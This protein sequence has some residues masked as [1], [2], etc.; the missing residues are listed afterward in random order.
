MTAWP[1]WL[2]ALAVTL[3][4]AGCADLP[5]DQH[6]WTARI[7]SSRVL[8]VG[9]SATPGT[10]SE[11]E[12]RE[13]RLVEQVAQKLGA[14]IAWR[15][16]NVHELLQELEELQLPLVVA[17]VPADSPFAARIGLSQPY[18][19]DG[20]HHRDYCLAVAPGENQLLLLVD[21]IIAAARKPENKP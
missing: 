19:K 6:G 20:P 3:P 21:Q 2:T 16:G 14:R 13:Q 4:L 12:E 10:L 7:H 8:T 9:V 17:T 15:R 11:L 18:L 1:Q 5:R